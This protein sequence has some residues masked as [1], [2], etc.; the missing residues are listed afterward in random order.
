MILVLIMSRLSGNNVLVDGARCCVIQTACRTGHL[1]LLLL[2][3]FLFDSQK[4]LF[5][6]RLKPKCC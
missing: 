6:E 3:I 4:N 1:N 2:M 5:I